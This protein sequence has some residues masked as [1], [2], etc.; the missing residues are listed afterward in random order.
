MNNKNA[1]IQKSP[2]NQPA[3]QE[4]RRPSRAEA[5][6]AVRTLLQWAGEDIN[7][8]GLVE[9]PARVVRAYEEFFKGYKVTNP[10]EVL[11]KTFEDIENYNDF[12]LVR[13]IEF[14]S[15]CEHHMVP[16]IGRAHVAYWPDARV[17]GISKLARI[18]DIFA[19]RLISQE[20]MTRQIRD[21]LEEALA[22]NGVAVIVDAVHHCMTLRGV[23]KAN[24]STLT[25]A[26]SG[27]FARDTSVQ[28]RFMEM[29]RDR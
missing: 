14:T 25:S 26:F 11:A 8:P 3:N 2:T 27:I 24:S 9:T 1:M 6:D 16:I 28:Q 20:N 23:R 15:H 13:D 22:P 29:C 19:C 21:T 10:A 5:E 12:V 4:C 18:V 17:V 7:R